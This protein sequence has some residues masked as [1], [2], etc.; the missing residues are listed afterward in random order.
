MFLLRMA[1]WLDK[2]LRPKERPNPALDDIIEQRRVA[3]ER[4]DDEEDTH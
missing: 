1:E 3:R 4:L 2:K